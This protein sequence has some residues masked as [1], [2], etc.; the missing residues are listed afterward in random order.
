MIFFR[1]KVTILVVGS[2]HARPDV[3]ARH[4]SPDGLNNP[5]ALNEALGY[6]PARDWSAIAETTTF[7]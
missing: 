5:L 7:Y 2:E 4:A 1:N 3:G 6:F